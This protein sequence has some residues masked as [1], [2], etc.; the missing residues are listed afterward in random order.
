[1]HSKRKVMH[2]KRKDSCIAR[3]EI[4]SLQE[5]IHALQEKIHASWEKD[6][7]I[8]EDQLLARPVP[9]CCTLKVGGVFSADILGSSTSKPPTL[10]DYP[11]LTMTQIV[12]LDPILNVT[13]TS[14]LQSRN[15]NPD[16]YD[17][18]P[19]IRLSKG[20]SSVRRGSIFSRIKH[21]FESHNRFEVAVELIDEFNKWVFKD[22]SSRSGRYMCK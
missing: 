13:T 21:P 10:D 17:I 7:C 4:R 5:K 2:S 14:V 20:E 18:S 16:K 22:V 12:E 11:N 9:I 8:T 3:K 1:M 15:R 19:Y 6:S